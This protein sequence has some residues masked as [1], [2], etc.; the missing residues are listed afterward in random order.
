MPMTRAQ[1]AAA[2]AAAPDADIVREYQRRRALQG[3][4]RPRK[5]S[6]CPKCGREVSARQKRKP[7]PHAV[8]P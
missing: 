3:A 2:L 7:C 5:L 4:G 1:I 6:T 8:A